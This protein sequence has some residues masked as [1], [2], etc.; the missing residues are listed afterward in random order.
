MLQNTDQND[1]QNTNG[2]SG[3]I[4]IFNNILDILKSLLFENEY[5][6]LW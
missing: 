4:P 6:A 1:Q 2:A 3:N 5:G